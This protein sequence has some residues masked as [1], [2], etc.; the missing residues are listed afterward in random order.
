MLELDNCSIL[1]R[2]SET[3]GSKFELTSPLVIGTRATP[4]LHRIPKEIRKPTDESIAI[5]I[6]FV[7]SGLHGQLGSRCLLSDHSRGWQRRARMRRTG[8]KNRLDI[9]ILLNQLSW[10]PS[11][12][13]CFN[14]I[15]RFSSHATSR[16]FLRALPTHSTGREGVELL[17]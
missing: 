8:Q 11:V 3:P 9:E 1:G 6:R 13:P 16:R 10:N 12:F 7:R 14:L 4:Q 17:N 2:T 15:A 5:V